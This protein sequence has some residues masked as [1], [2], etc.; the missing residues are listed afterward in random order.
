[1][2]AS[3]QLTTVH[4][5]YA[6]I[7]TATAVSLFGSIG[8]L[9]AALVAGVWWQV[10]AGAIREYSDTNTN[11]TLIE[12]DETCPS[13]PHMHRRAFSRIE[14]VVVVLLVAL[15]FGVMMPPVSDFDAM[16]QAKNSMQQ[17][18][19]AVAAY[20]AKHGCD[21]PSVV[22]RNGQ[23]IHSWRALILSELGEKRLAAAYRLDEPW[24]SPSNLALE[25]FRPWHYQPF[26]P[27]ETTTASTDRSKTHVH[28]LSDPGFAGRTDERSRKLVVEHEL[29]PTSWLAPTE[30]SEA[31]FSC[32]NKVPE[33]DRGF[34]RPGVF[35]SQY[36]GR[37]V[38]VGDEVMVVHPGV[39]LGTAFMPSALTTADLGSPARYYHVARLLRTILFVVVALYPLRWLRKIRA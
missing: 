15:L 7:L 25:G 17:I 11:Q 30:L 33:L 24:N 38:A 31:E 14:L 37:V 39:A 29:Y 12:H 19:R 23:P 35:V 3:N 28:L 8:I 9:V 22:Y 20:E 10:I 18:A 36:R 34:W 27:A 5:F 13:P 2:H 6:M 4:L 21:L 1:M 26:Y 16:Q 32:E